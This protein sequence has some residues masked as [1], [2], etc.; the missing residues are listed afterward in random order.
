MSYQL[1]SETQPAARKEHRCI[2]CGEQILKSEK[3]VHECSKWDGEFQDHRWHLECK[4]ASA[5]YFNQP[6]NEGDFMAHSFKRGT[7]NEY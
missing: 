6:Y 4:T 2:W 1:L 5:E 3:H 7:C